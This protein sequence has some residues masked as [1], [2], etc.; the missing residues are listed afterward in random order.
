[1]NVALQS[2]WEQMAMQQKAMFNVEQQR[3]A[4]PALSTTTLS[5][6]P[7]KSKKEKKTPKKNATEEN[8]G[9]YH[10]EDVTGLGPLE[11]H[12][13]I[14]DTDESSEAD[15]D[16][17]E[18][19]KSS[20]SKTKLKPDNRCAICDKKYHSLKDCPK[21][22]NMNVALHSYWEQM[23]MQKKAMFN[24]EQQRFAVPALS[25]TTLSSAP[26]KSKKEKKT[27]KKTKKTPQKKMK[28]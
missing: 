26:G 27:P 25:T 4:V 12:Y 10:Q 18:Q 15:E 22:P 3:F 5:S 2:Y 8:E 28:M 24:V 14:T 13:T 9:W 7:G 20:K 17:V 11:R 21:P 19:Q 16:G 1:M 23:A 6:A